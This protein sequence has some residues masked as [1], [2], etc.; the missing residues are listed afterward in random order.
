MKRLFKGAIII[1]ANENFDIIFNGMLGIKG[2]EIAYVGEYNSEFEKDFDADAIIHAS[3]KV[4]MPGLINM[5]THL[6]MTLLRGYASDLNLDAWLSEK[7]L[8]AESKMTAEDIEIGAQIAAAEMMLS[9]T[10]MCLDMYA[11]ADTIADVI[12]DCGM[13]GIVSYSYDEHKAIENTNNLSEHCKTLSDGRMKSIAAL[14]LNYDGTDD[15]EEI[16][17]FIQNAKENNKKIHIHVA[18]NQEQ[19]DKCQKANG[20]SPVKYL[21][22]LGLFEAS[23]IAVHCVAVSDKDL[24]I[25]KDN[26]VSVVYCPTSDAK[27]ASGF[28]PVDRMIKKGINVC[29]GTDGGASNNNMDMLEE[30]HIGSIIAK[31]ASRNPSLMNAEETIKMATINAAKALGLDH[32]IGSLEAGKK[33]DIIMF[34]HSSPFFLPENELC[35]N[36]VYSASRNEIEM[37]MVDGK[38]LMERGQ[39]LKYNYERLASK[40]EESVAKLNT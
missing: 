25:L 20:M 21:E 16:K 30:M 35:N 31:G 6:P 13:R 40:F 15:E 3:N 37:T 19:A 27:I 4:L 7:V 10:T 2:N 17:K 23:V 33:A 18:D 8:P 28:A 12:H 32:A 38:I 24:D 14:G 5:H 36:I 34:N 29:I 26:N 9:G 1:T 22:K 11:H 39:L